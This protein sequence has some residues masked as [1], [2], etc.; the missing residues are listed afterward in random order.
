MVL[1]NLKSIQQF[2][3]YDFSEKLNHYQN[4]RNHEF[5]FLTKNAGCEYG[6]RG[7]SCIQADCN[8]P[9]N[10]NRCCLTCLTQFSGKDTGHGNY[11]ENQVRKVVFKR[12]NSKDVAFYRHCHQVFTQVNL[13]YFRLFYFHALQIIKETDRRTRVEEETRHSRGIQFNV[14]FSTAGS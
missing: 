2:D 8:N 6:D 13:N 14:C 1:S 10:W 5:L 7:D 12:N 9:S 11:E 4:F 3:I